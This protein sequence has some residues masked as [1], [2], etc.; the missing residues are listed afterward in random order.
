MERTAEDVGGIITEI[1]ASILDIFIVG[2][3]GLGLMTK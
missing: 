3:I 2:L 1:V